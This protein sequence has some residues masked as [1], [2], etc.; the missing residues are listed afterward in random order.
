[1][2]DMPWEDVRAVFVAAGSKEIALRD[3]T[4]L[5]W[6]HGEEGRRRPEG[7]EDWEGTF[8][9]PPLPPHWDVLA[10]YG[11]V[12]LGGVRSALDFEAN[13]R[14]LAR[15]TGQPHIEFLPGFAT[16]ASFGGGRSHQFADRF[17]ARAI[18]SAPMIIG[19]PAGLGSENS[20]RVP[21]LYV[22]GSIDGRHLP[23]SAAFTPRLRELGALSA[24]APMFGLGHFGYNSDAIIWP[25]F[26]EMLEER[27]PED[28]DRQAIPE[29]KNYGP[30]EGWIVSLENLTGPGMYPVQ[31]PP[32]YPIAEAPEDLEYP[33]WLP[34]RRMV[35]LWRHFV[36]AQ[37]D[38]R[39]VYPT[40]NQ[41]QGFH[42][43]AYFDRPGDVSSMRAGESFPVIAAGPTGEDVEHHWHF[44]YEPIEPEW[45]DPE[46]P[47]HI[48]LGPQ[49][50][51]LHVLTLEV[52]R[53]D[54]HIFSR[55]IS[56]VFH[57]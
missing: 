46:N 48:R 54:R 31:N 11:V 2:D 12:R 56:V 14:E 13:M 57:P 26:L 28:W 6:D 49:E 42:N 25:F 3:R 20:R 4:R 23:D 44:N 52:R 10:Q 27:F 38:I 19:I 29:L 51:G 35:H 43:V 8:S 36:S 18:A 17:P 33:G 1:P 15:V 55:P 32:A 24:S 16:G 9:L 53:G 37:T 30:D 40:F 50:P 47:Y 21:T 41:A 45:T 22:W 5:A 34:N 7:M 39:I